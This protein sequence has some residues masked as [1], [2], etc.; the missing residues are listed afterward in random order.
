[1]QVRENLICRKWEKPAMGGGSMKKMEINDAG[2]A[3]TADQQ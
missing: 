2:N 1:M 3:F